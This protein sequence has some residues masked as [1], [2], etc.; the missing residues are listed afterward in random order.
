[1]RQKKHTA[2]R[3]LNPLI[4]RCWSAVALSLF[5]LQV[6]SVTISGTDIDRFTDSCSSHRYLDISS[7]GCLVAVIVLVFSEIIQ[8]LL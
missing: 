5:C 2:R 8:T 3:T 4:Q 7:K 1:M 6:S